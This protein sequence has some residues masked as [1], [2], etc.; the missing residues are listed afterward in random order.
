MTAI[1]L[2]LPVYLLALAAPTSVWA[3]NILCGAVL[4]WA[5]GRALWPGREHIMLPPRPVLLALGAVLLTHLLA[6]VL[7]PGPTRW[8]KLVEETWFKLLLVAVPVVLAGR[9]DAARRA[10]WLVLATG[11][12]AAVYGIYQHLT[13]TD[14]IARRT[15]LH[16]D[17]AAIAM[18]FTNHH[19]S[20]GGQ[21]VVL[22]ALA[23]GWLRDR[24]LLERRRAWLPALVCLVMGLALIW[25]FARS[26]QVGVFAAAVFLVLTL[27]RGPWRRLGT[28]GLVVLVAAVLA[29]PL[30]R[31]RVAESFT[32]EKEVTRPN[33]WRSSIA[34]I[35]DRPLTGWGPG[36]FRL[37]LEQHEV[38][39]YYESRAHSHNDFLM[40]AVNAGL[41]G[42]AA[43]LW[44]LIAVIR[45]CWSGWRR[46]GPG[47]WLLLGAVAAQVGISAA[48]MFQ[49]FQ[50]DD[51]VEIL[52]YLV[53]GCCLALAGVSARRVAA[54]S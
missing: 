3:S 16:F 34:G 4:A 9:G 23:M 47:S 29:M 32:D 26:A 37:M 46:G 43:T 22:M 31:S 39:G 15:L 6:A 53:L 41:L 14:P 24:V 44:L 49:V 2:V 8:Y 20:Y 13:D 33:L 18:G 50:T 45:A 52:L 35:A 21:L 42:L 27:P 12:L 28:A 36:N 5:L 54:G 1:L 10:L 48:G 19:L 25:S 17:G 51:E 38:P 40:H 30:V 7:A 11:T